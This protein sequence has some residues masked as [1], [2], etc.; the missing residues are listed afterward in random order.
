MNAARTFVYDP[1][2]DKATATARLPQVDLDPYMAKMVLISD[3]L[4]WE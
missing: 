3:T 2:T 1:L 4:A